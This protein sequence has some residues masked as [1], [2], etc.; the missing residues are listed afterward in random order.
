MYSPPEFFRG[1]PY[2]PEAVDTWA[3][4]ITLFEM[5]MGFLPFA[6]SEAIE[7][8]NFDYAPEKFVN[9]DALVSMWPAVLKCL[10]DNPL[11]RATIEDLKYLVK[12]DWYPVHT[13]FLY[14]IDKCTQCECIQCG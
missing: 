11:L 1:D 7:T 12:P 4:G 5:L 13:G 10:Q 3:M 14:R 8:M 2:A 6:D 9:L